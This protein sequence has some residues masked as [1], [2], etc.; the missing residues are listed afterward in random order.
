MKERC[1]ICGSESD[2]QFLPYTIPHFG[3]AILFVATCPACGFR[4][5]DVRILSEIK[6]KPKRYELVVSSVHDLNVRVIRSSYGRIEIP[7]LGVNV[8]PREGESFISTVEGVLKRVERVVEMLG[9]A[10]EGEKKRRAARILEE[11]EAIKLGKASMT[12]IIEDPTGNS[13]IIYDD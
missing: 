5:T 1:P 12:L 10:L 6:D 7:E 8:E 4:S 3:D 13:A 2:L 11:I 9:R